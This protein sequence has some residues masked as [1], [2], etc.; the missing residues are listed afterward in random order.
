MSPLARLHWGR[1]WH[2][3]VAEDDRDVVTS[4]LRPG[5]RSHDTDEN[6]EDEDNGN[7]DDCDEDDNRDD[8]HDDG[9]DSMLLAQALMAA[10]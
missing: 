5:R 1:R 2:M 10:L 4:F 9:D 3:A 8:D 7:G 6:H